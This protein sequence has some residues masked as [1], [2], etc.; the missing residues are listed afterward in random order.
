M[1][2]AL[3]HKIAALGAVIG[4]LTTL[5]WA[6]QPKRA[7]P[8]KDA[9][10]TQFKA[11]PSTGVLPPEE[12]TATAFATV[13][14]PT[15]VTWDNSNKLYQ[16]AQQRGVGADCLTPDPTR[17]YVVHVA[18][19]HVNDDSTYSLVSS[20]WYAYRNRKKSTTLVQ[21][22]LK[23]DGTPLL[24]AMKRLLLVGINFFDEFPLDPK[25]TAEVKKQ[26]LDT[27]KVII[28]YKV[29]ATEV[30]PENVVAFG[31]LIT[32]VMGLA[33][34]ASDASTSPHTV[35]VAA[36]CKDGP[37][38]LPFDINLTFS[39]SVPK[40]STDGGSSHDPTQPDQAP[41][42]AVDSQSASL[43]ATGAG[44]NGPASDTAN[45]P[46]TPTTK[47]STNK[48]GAIDCSA[49]GAKTPC[50]FT[51][52]F[53]SD[54]K[55]YWDVS[56][57]VTIPGLREAQYSDKSGTVQR[58]VTTHTDMYGLFDIYPL[59][60][61]LTKE[62]GIPHFNFGIPLTS[63]PFYRPYFG[64][65]ENLTSW[66]KLEKLGFPVRMSF[67]AGIAYMKQS[68]LMGLTPGATATSAQFSSALRGDRVLKPM[69]GVEVPVSA[70][71]SKIGKKSS[72]NSKSGNS[73]NSN[74]GGQ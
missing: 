19:W 32:A 57:G 7:T 48:S 31:Q 61:V 74:G 71:I 45:A 2:L 16:L 47:S 49:S 23:A 28:D 73:S 14:I 33:V 6:Q 22:R 24:Y 35:F 30:Q 13:E 1:K 66:T 68:V 26:Q 4:L 67:Y 34:K 62:S 70:L 44:R 60:K 56:I 37:D 69:Y 11:S 36:G 15:S 51:K 65:A 9:V 59:A 72:S 17:G 54:D 3:T 21:A 5:A 55:E 8:I 42:D 52:T 64:L 27:K 40:Q 50:T 58:K 25:A 12:S 10:T 43:G 20:E 18:Q 38:K 63:Q 29:S 39:L 46:K 41:S 53:R